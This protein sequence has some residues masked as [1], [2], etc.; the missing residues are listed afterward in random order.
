MSRERGVANW[1][2]GQK[3]K[4]QR[5]TS[6]K[7]ERK[8]GLFVPAHKEKAPERPE[9]VSMAD[10]PHDVRHSFFYRKNGIL[11]PRGQKRR[12]SPEYTQGSKEARR[13]GNRAH[14]KRVRRQKRA[15]ARAGRPIR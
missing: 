1:L 8:G 3:D 6:R 10:M 11:V 12:K 9:G 7:W 15:A 4:L 13:Q 2:S 5:A 14:A